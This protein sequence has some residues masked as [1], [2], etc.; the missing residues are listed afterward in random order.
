MGVIRSTLT[1]LSRHTWRGAE[2]I[3]ATGGAIVVANHL[4]QIDPMVMARFVYATGRVPR[5]LT[6]AAVLDAPLVGKALRST[7]QIAVY[8]GSMNAAKSLVEAKAALKAGDVVVLYP[9][10]TTTRQPDFWPMR[11]HTGVARLALAT[12]VPVIPV[13]QWGAQHIQDP[14]AHKL[15]LRPR[16][17]VTVVAGPPMDL[18]EWRS[19][20][21]GGA[22]GDLA[23]LT[24]AIM[25][26]I[27][28]LLAGIRGEQPPSELFEWT[29]KRS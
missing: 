15:N 14:Q 9:E 13:A 2:H 10:G 21:G 27:Q 8:R 24:D 17:P 16:T 7:G 5:F 12:D 3:P 20:S 6:K 23:G 28:D 29:S 25:Y 11:G 1:V 22:R 4:S 26:R 19:A 18:S